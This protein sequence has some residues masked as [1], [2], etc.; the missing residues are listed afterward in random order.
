MVSAVVALLVPFPFFVLILCL[1]DIVPFLYS[2]IVVCGK[3]RDRQDPTS[4]LSRLPAPVVG[5]S[6]GLF[7]D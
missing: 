5:Y 1:E 6:F 7:N 3:S 2:S 4:R